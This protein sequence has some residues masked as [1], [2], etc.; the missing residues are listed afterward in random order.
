[1]SLPTLLRSTIV[2]VYAPD[3][4]PEDL[5][6]RVLHALL[7]SSIDTKVV[8]V[9]KAVAKPTSAVN[10]PKLTA[11]QT[12]QMNKI[13]TELGINPT[14]IN[15]TALLHFCNSLTKEVFASAPLGVHI[16]NY[17]DPEQEVEGVEETI[18]GKVYFVMGNRV[19]ENNKF[20]GI[21]GQ[22]MF[23]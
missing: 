4:T 17:L 7:D 23:A 15:T 3:L 11:A 22:G 13:A 19:Y 21:K 14:E 9:K 18:H 8:K 20:A 2:N 16:R 10:V 5:A 6:T 12:K 1:M